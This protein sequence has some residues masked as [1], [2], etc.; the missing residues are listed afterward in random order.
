MTDS[1]NAVIIGA[2][3]SITNRATGLRV[4]V[5]TN[6]AGTFNSGPLLPGDFTLQVSANGFGVVS[7][8][9]TVLVGNTASRAVR[10]AVEGKRVLVDVN[11]SFGI[12]V[13]TQ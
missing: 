13:N 11:S 4:Q 3:I 7:E 5:T 1:S 10:L 12:Q 8:Q 9:I 6:S 2:Q